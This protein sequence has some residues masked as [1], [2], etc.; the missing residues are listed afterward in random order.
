MKRIQPSHH[1]MPIDQE[2]FTQKISKNNSSMQK[3]PDLQCASDFIH[4]M[5]N[6]HQQ[7]VD[8]SQTTNQLMFNL[9]NKRNNL[10]FQEKYAPGNS[11]IQSSSFFRSR[12]SQFKRESLKPY[13]NNSLM[14]VKDYQ[15]RE[16]QLNFLNKQL[17]NRSVS[18]TNNTQHRRGSKVSSFLKDYLRVG[19][20]I[21]DSEYEESME[22][23]IK[24]VEEKVNLITQKKQSQVQNQDYNEQSQQ[25]SKVQSK[26]KISQR[27]SPR[28]EQNLTSHQEQLF[29]DKDQSQIS[30]QL[31]LEKKKSQLKSFLNKQKL[32]V[33]K[34]K[35]YNQRKEIQSRN[36]GLLNPIEVSNSNHS[37][38]QNA[39]G[40]Q[41]FKT[42]QDQNMQ[43][44]SQ[45]S[46]ENYPSHQSTFYISRYDYTDDGKSK[47]TQE[48]KIKNNISALG[49]Y[50]LLN[51]VLPSTN[52][53]NMKQVQQNTKQNLNS[54]EVTKLLL[55]KIEQSELE[56]YRLNL[57]VY[58]N[59]YSTL[60]Y[61]SAAQQS[62]PQS[63][64]NQKDLLY[65]S[66]NHLNSKNLLCEESNKNIAYNLYQTQQQFIQ[67]SH[68]PKRQS[69]LSQKPIAIFPSRHLET[70]GDS[71]NNRSIDQTSSIYSGSQDEQKL[72]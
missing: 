44:N 22:Q 6:R 56:K 62:I 16:N 21:N 27:T 59:M 24:D 36:I 12:L 29:I 69:V 51:L 9:E 71:R 28:K 20:G 63:K 60:N 53:K 40:N 64:Q 11:K 19:L 39:K 7:F 25:M 15:N 30:H 46:S 35:F 33:F 66:T 23:A 72:K 18:Q 5:D 67:S 54:E 2:Q 58:T 41:I 52:H 48:R 49:T 43:H 37:T 1:K 61:N 10:S 34:Q 42:Y 26:N 14:E 4:T 68:Q 38:L 70:A 3:Y 17:M 57:N 47:N 45:N 32:Q 8:Y 65:L 55:E 31:N 13:Q 50:R